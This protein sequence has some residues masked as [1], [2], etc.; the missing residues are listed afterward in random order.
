[1]VPAADDDDV[2]LGIFDDE[3][4]GT[5]L[6]EEKAKT[7]FWRRRRHG[8]HIHHTHEMRMDRSITPGD[9]VAGPFPKLA[10]EISTYENK[11]AKMNAGV[12]TK[13]NNQ[14]QEVIK[15]YSTFPGILTHSEKN[16]REVIR[17]RDQSAQE[18]ATAKASLDST[19]KLVAQ[20]QSEQQKTD[21]LLGSLQEEATRAIDTSNEALSRGE[22]FRNKAIEMLKVS[23]Q[24]AA[25]GHAAS[26][27]AEEAWQQT[28]QISMETMDTQIESKN[29]LKQA[30]DSLMESQQAIN[31][32]QG[33]IKSGKRAMD[34]S[35]NALEQATSATGVAGKIKFVTTALQSQQQVDDIMQTA[36]NASQ[37]AIESHGKTT[38]ASL[39]ALEAQDIITEQTLAQLE[40]VRVIHGDNLRRTDK[41]I[42]AVEILNEARDAGVAAMEAQGE[43]LDAAMRAQ[44]AMN[45]AIGMNMTEGLRQRAEDLMEVNNL[46]QEV[47]ISMEDKREE[48]DEIQSNIDRAAEF[49]PFGDKNTAVCAWGM[50]AASFVIVIGTA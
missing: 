20:A 26:E 5:A 18:A 11:L 28:K 50:G 12:Q 40:G 44:G 9:I 10:K 25:D 39:K 3:S 1:M 2:I 33:A 14:A 16:A 37:A 7:G 46:L 42:E 32:L 43:A 8:H 6:L 34:E 41:A 13:I 47:R 23:G 45:R 30:D 22:I 19:M 29:A 24:A 21:Q 49:D 38:K 4:A 27:A 48:I 35:D 17:F 36:V 15:T 31:E